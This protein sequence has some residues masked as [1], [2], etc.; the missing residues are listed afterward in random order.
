MSYEDQPR[1]DRATRSNDGLAAGGGYGDDSG[2]G[3]G[4]NTRTNDGLASG[5]GSGGY[6]GDD[7][8]NSGGGYGSSGMGTRTNDGLASTG[9]DGY[10]GGSSNIGGGGYGDGGRSGDNQGFAQAAGRSYD[11]SS[12]GSKMAPSMTP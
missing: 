3:G 4:G 9:D 5:G 7:S 10:G 8:Y 1:R 2:Y 12:Y 11:D 6:G